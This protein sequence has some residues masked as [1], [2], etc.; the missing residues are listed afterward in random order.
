VWDVQNGT[1]LQL[2]DLKYIFKAFH[3]QKELTYEEIVKIYS[4]PPVFIDLNYPITSQDLNDK[5]TSF[6]VLSTVE[7]KCLAPVICHIV[8][9][10]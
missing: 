1:L 4:E 3:G 8:D 5:E 7:E 9:L 10:Q 6:W 2:S